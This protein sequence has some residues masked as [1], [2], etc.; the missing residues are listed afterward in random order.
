[1]E[2]ELINEN[3]FGREKTNRANRR[4]GGYERRITGRGFEEPG[5]RGLEASLNTLAYPGSGD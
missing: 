5:W 1:M 4:A 3:H 2:C